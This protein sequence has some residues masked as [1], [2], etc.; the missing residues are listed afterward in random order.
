MNIE[1]LSLDQMRV[2]LAVAQTGSFAGA[3]RH[4]R[5]AQS[6]VS[7]AI[8]TL[9]QQ[10]GTVLFERSGQGAR[11]SAEGVSLLAEM[12]DIVARAD[13][14]KRRAKAIAAGQEPVLRLSVDALYD[15]AG[16]G[17]TWAAFAEEYPSTRLIFNVETMQRVVEDL[18]EGR[19]DLGILASL[20]TVPASLRS[21][22]LAPI[23]LIPVVRA[24]HPLARESHFDDSARHAWVQIVLGERMDAPPDDQYFVFASRT[25]R[26]T[27]LASKRAMLCAGVGWGYMPEHA[28]AGDI[29]AGTLVHLQPEGIPSSDPQPVFAMWRQETDPGPCLR[30]LLERLA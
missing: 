17:A 29:E 18:L 14:L 1:G 5:R 10:L 28:I 8:G 23:R 6:A 21:R 15:I 27:D 3:A 24:G 9:E 25:W 12:A 19:A 11:A 7:Y 30:W 26:V 22:T 4:V 16:N 2:A 20:S 13:G